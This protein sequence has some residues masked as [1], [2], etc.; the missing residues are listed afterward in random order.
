M[1]TY[2]K[3]PWYYDE[4]DKTVWFNELEPTLICEVVGMDNFTALHP[5]GKRI[6]AC[7]NACAGIL[8]EALEAGVVRDM[9]EALRYYFQSEPRCRQCT[10]Q[11]S[12][13]CTVDLANSIAWKILAKLEPKP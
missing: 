6:V 11:E 4:T 1:T 7:V 3:E 9:V 8:T 12:R 10:C 2:T 13:Q 5:N